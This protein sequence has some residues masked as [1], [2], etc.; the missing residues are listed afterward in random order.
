MLIQQL[1]VICP[2]PADISQPDPGT[3]MRSHKHKFEAPDSHPSMIILERRARKAPA[4]GLDPLH[5][6]VAS[7]DVDS[8]HG[9]RRHLSAKAT[10]ATTT[11]SR[12]RH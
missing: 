5:E 2:P 4:G 9:V 11:S 12:H 8:R 10:T 1:Q 3:Y 7:G 6:L